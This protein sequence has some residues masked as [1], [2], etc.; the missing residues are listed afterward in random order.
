MDLEN[1]ESGLPAIRAGAGGSASGG[2]DVSGDEPEEFQGGVAVGEVASVP[3]DLAEL[4]VHGLDQ[5]RGVDDLAQFWWVGQERREP[6]PGVA[7]EPDDAGVAVSPGQ[8]EGVHG[9]GRGVSV[10][11]RVDGLEG[12]ED[13]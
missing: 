11:R 7:P 2:G 12:I 6:F 4:V 8:L 5:V 1:V 9:L 3:R 10:D 13:A